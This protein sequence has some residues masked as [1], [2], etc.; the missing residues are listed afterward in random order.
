MSG[1]RRIRALG[2]R[3]I[4][5][6]VRDFATT[7]WNEASPAANM[8]RIDEHSRADI[9]ALHPRAIDVGT[10]QFVFNY[11]RSFC[12]VAWHSIVLIEITSNP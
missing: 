10:M 12:S 9:A 2:R 7:R 1:V 4:R 3:S 6:F 5:D 11:A 8:M